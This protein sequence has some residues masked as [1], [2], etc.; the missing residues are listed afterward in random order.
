[1]NFR[2]LETFIAIVKL[3]SFAAASSRLNATQSAVSARIMELERDLGVQLF[4]RRG[5]R[6]HL[7]VKGRELLRYAE[8]AL[9]LASEIKHRVGAQETLSGLVRLGV[10]ELVAVSWLPIFVTRINEHHPLIS[11][12]CY[13]ALTRDVADQLRAGRLDIALMPDAATGS[14]YEREPIGDAR[15]V[16]MASP[17]LGL[18]GRRLSLDE[19]VRHRWISLGPGSVYHEV[20]AAAAA[21][22]GNIRPIPIICNSMNTVASLTKAGLGV[23]LLASNCYDPEIAAEHLVVLDTSE[24][25]PPVPFFAIYPRG[26][27]NAVHRAVAAMAQQVSTFVMPNAAEHRG[28]E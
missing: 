10:A 16:W 13:V 26:C 24:I 25:P 5:R 2:Q 21:R 3:G 23:S 17:M 7:T 27:Q 14:D 8:L 6:A 12:E 28:G 4:D 22:F 11:L 18:H 15:F 20:E 9:E 1:M 19:L